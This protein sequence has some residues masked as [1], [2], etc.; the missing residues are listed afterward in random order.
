V[1]DGIFYAHWSHGRP[2]V[3]TGQN[4]DHAVD[5]ANCEMLRNTVNY[6]IS[7]S[8]CKKL[9]PAV[10]DAGGLAVIGYRDLLGICLIEGWDKD[11]VFKKIWT[12]GAK[13]LLDGKTT[14]ETYDMLIA[15]Y[16]YWISYWV[17]QPTSWIK[18]LM[19]NM[20]TD[21][22]NALQLLGMKHVRIRTPFAKGKVHYIRHLWPYLPWPYLPWLFR[23][24][25]ELP[26][27]KRLEELPF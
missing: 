1:C 6:W 2:D 10:I 9:G 24:P 18:P 4:Y 25:R 5:L 8:S 13:S 19:I 22:R 11:E 12:S 26:S 20:L 14:K 15:R 17:A 16:N 23:F 3:L 21:D 27:V 7:C